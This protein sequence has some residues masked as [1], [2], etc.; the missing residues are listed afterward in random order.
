MQY[1]DRN[2]EI[3]YLV[4]GKNDARAFTTTPEVFP[5][6]RYI[7]PYPRAAIRDGAGAYVNYYGY[8]Y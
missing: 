8:G 3:D 1:R 7:L 6:V 4:Y 2:T 5:P